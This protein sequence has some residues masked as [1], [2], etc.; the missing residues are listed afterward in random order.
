MGGTNDAAKFDAEQIALRVGCVFQR[1]HAMI[2][3]GFWPPFDL[4]P[5]NIHPLYPVI[6]SE[7]IEPNEFFSIDDL[8]GS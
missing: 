1:L 3:A 2:F 4:I 7:N 6:P 8:M 5:A